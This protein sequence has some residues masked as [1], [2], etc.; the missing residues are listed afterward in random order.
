MT[1]LSDLSVAQRPAGEE[2]FADS[3][4]E[5]YA[6][7]EWLVS[8]DVP[9]PNPD[10]LHDRRIRTLVNSLRDFRMLHPQRAEIVIFIMKLWAEG[11]S[12]QDAL[13]ARAA[14]FHESPGRTEREFRRGFA[15]LTPVFEIFPRAEWRAVWFEITDTDEWRR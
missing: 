5:L 6:S 7:Q 13:A 1:E 12:V 15:Q 10:R 11:H 9:G 2:G 14:R 4:R 3:Y 8:R